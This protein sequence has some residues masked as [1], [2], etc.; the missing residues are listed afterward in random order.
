M[1]LSVED[2][3]NMLLFLKTKYTCPI[4]RKPY[5][6]GSITRH[7]RVHTG[8]KPHRCDLCNKT[9]IQKSSLTVHYRTHTGEKPYCC[10]QCG[11]RFSQTQNLNKHLQMH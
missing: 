1:S 7:M 9:F 4:C 11:K 5:A 10:H 6:K 8:N 2:V 3:A